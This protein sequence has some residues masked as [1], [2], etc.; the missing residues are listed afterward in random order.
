MLTRPLLVVHANTIAAGDASRHAV[1]RVDTALDREGLTHF[2]STQQIWRIL[3]EL[4]HLKRGAAFRGVKTKQ[5][6]PRV[7]CAFE[8]HAAAQSLNWVRSSHTN[9]LR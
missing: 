5:Q 3:A 1:E 2:P 9:I 7:S 8:S 6:Y 4:N